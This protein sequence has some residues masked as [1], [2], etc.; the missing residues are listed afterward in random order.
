MILRL[1]DIVMT[2]LFGFICIATLDV[3]GMEIPHSPNSEQ[4]PVLPGMEV[5]SVEADG[6]LLD[7]TNKPIESLAELE[8]RVLGGLDRSARSQSGAEPYTYVV[9]IRVDRASPAS[10]IRGVVKICNKHHVSC[11]IAVKQKSID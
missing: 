7:E 5:V 11:A 3:S 2:L 8:R 10:A 4:I 1:I 9:K 6:R